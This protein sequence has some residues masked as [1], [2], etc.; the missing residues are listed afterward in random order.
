MLVLV[1]MSNMVFYKPHPSKK[2]PPPMMIEKE[3]HGMLIPSL[4]LKWGNI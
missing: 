4:K 3:W 1:F 2:N